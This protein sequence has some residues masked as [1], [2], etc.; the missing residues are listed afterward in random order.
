MRT[1]TRRR[2]KLLSTLTGGSALIAMGLL[3]VAHDEGRP[4]AVTASN[5]TIGQTT[6]ETAPAVSIAPSTLTAPVARPALKA[7]RP[8][9]F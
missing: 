1:S 3:A 5:M 8:K 4:A 2:A 6:T 9:G 7:P